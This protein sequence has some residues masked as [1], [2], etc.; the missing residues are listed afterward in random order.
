MPEAPARQG[1][2]EG[3]E[4]HARSNRPESTRPRR[5]MLPRM[6]GAS[7]G[8]LV[9]IEQHTNVGIRQYVSGYVGQLGDIRT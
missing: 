6:P 8:C 4:G 5:H 2:P 7:G 3:A 1:C 9:E